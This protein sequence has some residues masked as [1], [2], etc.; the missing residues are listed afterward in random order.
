MRPSS[1]LLVRIEVALADAGKLSDQV[2]RPH[3]F[4]ANWIGVGLGL[5][6]A[7]TFLLLAR[8]DFHP[9][10]ESQ[11]ASAT[12]PLPRE[13]AQ[14]PS[15]EP[16]ALTQVVYKKRDEGLVFPRGAAQP[17][18]RL[19]TSSREILQWQDARSGAQ[20]K[21]SYPAEEIVLIPVSGQ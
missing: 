6:V 15:Y 18:R 8:V 20:L 19:R 17:M 4:R 10:K 9:V 2:I 16:A 21:V 14:L 7:A 12:P 1:G 3:R 13:A 5:A 11:V